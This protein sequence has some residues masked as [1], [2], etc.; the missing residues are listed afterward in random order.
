MPEAFAF[1]RLYLPRPITA[2]AV[3]ALV[4]RL[5]GSDVSRPLSF[6]VRADDNGIQ[7]VLGCTATSVHHMKRLLAS[8]LPGIAFGSA[9]RS[10]IVSAGRV[11]AQQRGMPTGAP[12]PEHLTAAIYSALSAR[13]RGETLV[14]QV[15][16]GRAF[17]P[18]QIRPDVADPLQPLGSRMWHG[19]KRAAPETRR[20]LQE[21]SV[22]TRRQVAVRIG[23]AGP[24]PKR[25]A[26]LVSGLFGGLHGLG[27]IGV[28]LRLT[29]EAATNLH[30]ASPVRARLELTAR[31]LAP[32][33]GW[34]LGDGNLPGVDPL[35]PKRLPVPKGIST[36]ESLFA[37]GTAPG[38]ERPVGF[39]PAGRL[40]HSV[41]IGPTG[42]GKSVLLEHLILADIAAGRACAV[43]EPKRQL[44]DS[45]LARVPASAAGQVVV[46]DAADPMPVGFNPCELGEEDDPYVVADNL[47]AAFKAL[48]EDG[49]GPRT[50]YLIQGALVTL[51][52]AGQRRGTPYTL[53]DLPL[54]LTDAALR[55]EAVKHVTDDPA[56]ATFWAEFEDL[57]VR[58][59]V[60]QIAAPLNKL[61]KL[62]MRKNL[63]AVLGQPS[64]RFKLRNLFREG[65]T[66]LVPL[67]EAL[68]G[69]GAANFLGSLVLAELWT[70]T[71]KRATEQEPWKRPG[72]I[73]VDEVQNYL[74]LPTDIGDAMATSRSY[75][76]AWAVAHQFRGQ[77]PTAM[78]EGFDT[79]ARSKFVFA[80]GPKDAADLAKHA[81]D[82]TAEDFQRLG[83]Y[84][85]YGRL[86]HD[87]APTDWFS[88]RTLPPTPVV[89][90]QAELLDASSSLYGLQTP[91]SEPEE[92]IAPARPAPL[93]A[94]SPGAPPRPRGQRARRS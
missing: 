86:V 53:I 13:R 2:D 64:P 69:K 30:F 79:N 32:L 67:N 51:L 45:V 9:T 28:R 83:K 34:P 50:E 5:A 48:F 47:L 75:G 89:G 17:A 92:S 70:A 49:W 90:A 59:R 46:L 74:H 91:H 88:A 22:E 11:E 80:L 42:S 4:S 76:V 8:H 63:V 73:F 40:Q 39:D 57:P 56:L 71:L 62:V 60:N 66:V 94:V 21:H 37:V 14:L 93:A 38:P 55:L 52:I 72:M 15:V 43:V 33:L 18:Q 25:R 3:T 41:A 54:L 61:R 7:H 35:H 16:L 20:R 23:V 84:E 24:D 27:T 44:I 65:K 36:K 10:P 29:R 31:E 6:E 81:P 12:D 26:A 58:Q 85:I 87:G 1:T 78:R 19:V 82:L 77:L 68:I